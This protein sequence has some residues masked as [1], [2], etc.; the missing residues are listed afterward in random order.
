MALRIPLEWQA[1]SGTCKT[2]KEQ[3]AKKVESLVL[4]RL[5]ADGRVPGSKKI[6]TL[7]DFSNR[8]FNWLESLPADRPPK[9]PT[10]GF[11]RVGWWVLESTPITGMKLDQITT[12]HGSIIEG[13]SAAN[14]NN[15]LRTLRR[16]LKKAP[17]WQLLSSV[18]IVKLVEEQ[19]REELIEPWMEQRL[20]TV[21]AGP[22]LTGKGKRSRVGW[23]PFRTI[24]LIMLDSGLRPGEIFRMRWEN[25]HWDKGL[26]FNP[27]GKSRKSRRYVPLTQRVKAALLASRERAS[28]GWVFPSKK[29]QSGH[30]TGHEVSKQWLEAKRSTGIPGSVV[31]Y[32][33]RRRFSTD[34]TEGT[35]NVMAVMD[36]MGHQ[37]VNTTR[38]YNHSN[39]MQIREAIERRNQQLSATVQ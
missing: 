13:L 14:T 24:L 11:C 18:P 23:E 5:L 19:G 16:M 33:A 35:G 10:P 32:C 34:A 38:I 39:V 31:L 37:S 1:L 30:I 28:E 27:R 20:L 15:A 29:A 2:S 17:E 21:T 9:A 22:R 8:S 3:E 25:I 7:S 4:A 26:I 36:A 12:D 6:P